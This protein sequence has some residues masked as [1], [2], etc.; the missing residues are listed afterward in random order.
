MRMA[1]MEKIAR[2]PSAPTLVRVRGL[3]SRARPEMRSCLAREERGWARE[4]G[5]EGGRER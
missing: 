5:R 3:R 4:G 1:V 2:E